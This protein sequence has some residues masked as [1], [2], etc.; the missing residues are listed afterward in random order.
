MLERVALHQTRFRTPGVSPDP[1]GVVLG[2]TGAVLFPSLDRFVAFLRA[3]GEE[4][5]LDELLPTLSIRRVITPLK[6]REV[7]FTVGAE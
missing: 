7:L 3:Y 5:S 2:Q 6:T 4:G 1:R